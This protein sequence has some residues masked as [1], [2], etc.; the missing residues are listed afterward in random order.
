MKRRHWA[1]INARTAAND[2][3]LCLAAAFGEAREIEEF[4]EPQTPFRLWLC[5]QQIG[6][7]QGVNWL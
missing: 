3:R 4:I 6:L 5:R 1:A 7:T 2:Q